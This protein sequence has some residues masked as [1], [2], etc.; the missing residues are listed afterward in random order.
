M[1]AIVYVAS[2]RVRGGIVQH[3]GNPCAVPQTLAGEDGAEIVMATDELV[4]ISVA[5]K[6]KASAAGAL[7]LQ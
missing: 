6:D 7:L 3:R 2:L 1:S 5:E 4:A